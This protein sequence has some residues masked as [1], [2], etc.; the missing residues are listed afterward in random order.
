M[1]DL[2]SF[3]DNGSDVVIFN[4]GNAGKVNNVAIS[5]K[6]KSAE[7]NAN[8]PDYKIHYTQENGSDVNDGIYYPQDSDNNPAFVLQRL[9]T[10]LHAVD[11]ESIGVALPT[12]PN[13]PAAVDFLMKKINEAGKKGHKVNV[14][15][16]YGTQG[17]PKSFLTVRKINFVE[18]FNK[19]ENTTRLKPAKSTDANKLMYNDLMSRPQPD[20][21]DDAF[22]TESTDSKDEASNDFF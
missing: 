18:P 8:A 1:I 19:D 12:L 21:D 6:K 20:N 11:A 4:E 13:Y 22:D 3:S 14:F 5:V 7:D 17:Y 15:V 10:T 9:V 16:N 2:N